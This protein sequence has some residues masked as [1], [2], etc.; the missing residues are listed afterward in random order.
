[1]PISSAYQRFGLSAAFATEFEI[2]PSKP[3][4]SAASSG[5][6]DDASAAIPSP[7]TATSATGSSQMNSR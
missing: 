7:A 4:D 2:R 3:S 5:E 1:M 6:P